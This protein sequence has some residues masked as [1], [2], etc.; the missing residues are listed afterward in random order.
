MDEQEMWRFFLELHS[1]NAQEGPGNF[2]STRRALELV[3][4]LPAKPEILD[5]GCGPGRQTLDLLRLTDGTITAVDNQ[6][7]YLDDLG[8]RAAEQG[9][10]D[11]VVP[12]VADMARL[13]L[14]A[15]SFDLVW[16]EGALYC[17]GFEAGLKTVRPLLND[18]GALAVTELTRL[19]P[20][21]P[22]EGAAF[23]QGEYPAMQD[24]AGNV[25]LIE[26]AGYELSGHFTLPEAAWREYYEPLA[27]KFDAFRRR[28]A[29][30]E[31][32][33]AVLAMEEREQSMYWKYS[34]YFG[35]VFY[36]A[37]VR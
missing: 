6:P 7:A 3:D 19:A 29:G 20:G 8:R 30:S 15:G 25:A 5:L 11:R 22:E 14:P 10:A 9:D 4:G 34:G 31:T 24:I 16:S 1:G 17:M 27:R 21:A 36:V 2:A 12:V 37:K 13:E 28:H 35:Y 18:G 23:W 33:L 32:A 26:A